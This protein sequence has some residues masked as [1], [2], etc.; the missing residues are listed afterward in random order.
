[1]MERMAGMVSR[2]DGTQPNGLERL[3]CLVADA[4]RGEAGSQVR[5]LGALDEQPTWLVNGDWRLF[6]RP[7]RELVTSGTELAQFELPG[8]SAVSASVDGARTSVFLPFDPAE[9]HENYLAERW[10]LR[11]GR[12]GLTPRQLNLFYKTKRFIPRRLQIKA[13]R[14]LIKRQ[15]SPE[16]PRWPLDLSVSRLL[17]FYAYCVLCAQGRSEAP[18]RWFW[19]DGHKAALILTHD[20]ETAEGLRLAVEIADLEES[21]GLRSSFNL[22]GWY[23]VDPGILRE[24]VDRGFEIGLHG[25]HHDRSLFASRAAFERQ[26]AQLAELAERFGATGFRSPATHRVFD[27]LAELPVSY[28]CSIPH[29]DPFEPQPGG[30]CSLWPFFIGDV[31]ELPYTLPQDYTLFTLLGERTPDLWLQQV[32]RIVQE[33]GLVQALTHP[34]P[35]Y[36]GSRANRDCYG[37]FLR[38]MAGRDDVWT[39]LPREVAEWW[40]RRDVG[41]GDTISEGTIRIGDAL[42]E[43][44]L[45]PPVGVPSRPVQDGSTQGVLDIPRRAEGA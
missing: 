12:R 7:A 19:P 8:G 9:A 31:V 44:V 6:A 22:G 29:S 4:A 40:R 39:A 17:R 27:W 23:D 11:A 13:R 25:L 20:V 26:R 10:T 38:A 34:D 33:H 5:V 2:H 41:S 30:C 16:F 35:G 24:L 15:G 1:M 14:L 42:D 18:F 36:L 37:E 3:L 32:D 28:D 45:E 21:N 43:V